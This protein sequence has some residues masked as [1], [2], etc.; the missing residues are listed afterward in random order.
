[1]P[2]VI[3]LMGAKTAGKDTVAQ[4][5]MELNPL[6]IR[7]A[8]ADILKKMSLAIDPI[9]KWNLGEDGYQ[10]I[11]CEY[12]D[13]GFD[14]WENIEYARLSTVVTMFGWDA[15]KTVPEVRQFLQRLGTEGGRE[16]IDE[17]VWVDATVAKLDFDSDAKYVFTD[18]RFP[19]EIEKVLSYADSQIWRVDRAAVDNQVDIHP[20]ELAWRSHVPD[21]VIQNS[22]T[23][24]ELREAVQKALQ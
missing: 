4:I 6:F 20:S 7:V 11:L 3:G 14:E 8:F 18:V 13:Y 19:N 9:V 17:N 16:C 10:G 1:M 15:A 22:G 21:V 2:K 23:F 5:I 24:D 12:D